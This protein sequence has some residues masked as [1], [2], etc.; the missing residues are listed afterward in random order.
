VQRIPYAT[1]WEAN[2][3]AHHYG[4]ERCF[5]EWDGIR[6]TA[7]LLVFDDEDERQAYLDEHK[8]SDE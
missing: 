5:I 3:D 8:D 1:Q 7:W 2:G 4:I 6:E